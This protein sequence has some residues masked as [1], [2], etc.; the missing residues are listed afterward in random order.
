MIISTIFSLLI[1]CELDPVFEQRLKL[2]MNLWEY[3]SHLKVEKL[4]FFSRLSFI[5]EKQQIFL[6]YQNTWQIFMKKVSASKTGLFLTIGP[7][8]NTDK[9]LKSMFQLLKPKQNR[10]FLVSPCTIS[11]C[12]FLSKTCIKKKNS[13]FKSFHTKVFQQSIS[14]CQLWQ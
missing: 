7:Y 5:E 10:S 13:Y 9:L 8:P 6:L 11:R 14:S 2:L 3:F 1:L 4:V 12:I